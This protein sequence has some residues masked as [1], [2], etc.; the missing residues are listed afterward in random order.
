M[1]IIKNERFTCKIAETGA[2][3]CSLQDTAGREY[4]WQGL[5]PY[6]PS[7]AINLF[8]VCG[9]LYKQMYT[10]KGKIYTI[11]NHG[12]ARKAVF[13]PVSH[14][15][16]AVTL[17]L[18]ASPETKAQYP[19]DFILDISFRL[20][21]HKL[22]CGYTV[23]NA[24]KEPMPYAVGA[25]PGFSVEP[26]ED[27][28]VEF[29]GAPVQRVF[30]ENG[31]DVGKTAPY[32]FAA[33]NRI[34]LTHRLFDNDSLFFENVGKSVRLLHKNGG[35]ITVTCPEANFWGIW[36]SP[37]S[38]APFVCIEPWYGAP[39][40]EGITEA[41][42]TREYMLRLAPGEEKTFAYTVEISG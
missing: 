2:E 20:D 32:P 27:Y 18:T 26:I 36:H 35:S 23:R 24:G 6:W 28:T 38:D 22:H 13:S 19:F 3:L 31:L 12:F 42:E 5:A 11:G 34:P 29:S 30:D 39:G 14:T 1:Q 21:G 4:I 9:R 16:D 40:R 15:G 37:Q 17:R 8:P 33:G 41:L 25:H 7:H 10:Y